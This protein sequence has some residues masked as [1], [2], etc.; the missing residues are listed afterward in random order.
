[1][2]ASIIA[3]YYKFVKG[4]TQT[5]FEAQACKTDHFGLLWIV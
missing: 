3:Q 5:R 4:K 2:I 1:L